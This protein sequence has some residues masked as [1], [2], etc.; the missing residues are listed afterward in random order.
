MAEAAVKLPD[1]NAPTARAA[2][3]WRT[4]IVRYGIALA[5]VAIAFAARALLGPV[6]EDQ[7]P[8]LF[9]VP[10]VLAA[11]GLGGLGPGLLATALA[12]LLVSFSS[13]SFPIFPR[14]KP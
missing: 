5:S 10:A 14:P 7:A 13:R 6:L 9:F 8:H 12:L 11:A 2:P 3:T 1:S 4:D